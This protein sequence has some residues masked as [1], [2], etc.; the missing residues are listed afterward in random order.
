[1][2]RFEILSLPEVANDLRIQKSAMDYKNYCSIRRDLRKADAICSYVISLHKQLL[3]DGNVLAEMAGSLFLV[4]GALMH[5]LILY[6]RWFK[7]TNK[8]PSLQE[9]NFF[10]VG[11]TDI[12]VHGR[13]IQLRDKYIA[14]YE[15]DLLGSDKIWATFDDDGKFIETDSDWSE[16]QFVRLEDV[17]MKSFQQ[18]IHIVHNK[19]DAVLLPQIQRTLNSQLATLYP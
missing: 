1:M 12:K 2:K 9:S 5:A 18:C 3:A 13:L 6:G 15:L 14:H 7:A 4:N 11:S 10:V 17:D 8:K 19:I 16:Q